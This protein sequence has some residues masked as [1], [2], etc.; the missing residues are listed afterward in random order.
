MEFNKQTSPNLEGNV[1]S[2]RKRSAQM[3]R[4]KKKARWI[5]KM[6]QLFFKVSHIKGYAVSLG[7]QGTVLRTG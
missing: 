6:F 7:L 1:G 3:L 4:D 5:L 2:S